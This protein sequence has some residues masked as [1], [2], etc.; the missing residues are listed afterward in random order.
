[1]DYHPGFPYVQSFSPP[2]ITLEA[3]DQRRSSTTT[4]TKPPPPNEGGT[5]I[6][7]QKQ[8]VHLIPTLPTVGPGLL[9]V[10]CEA[11]TTKSESLRRREE[12]VSPNATKHC[13]RQ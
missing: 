4:A 3:E 2:G 7:I 8:S 1:M 9:D 13:Q 10:V 5:S 6:P 12:A 11:M